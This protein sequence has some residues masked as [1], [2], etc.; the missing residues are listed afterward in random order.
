MC[1]R[2][3]VGLFG[4][5]YKWFKNFYKRLNTKIIIINNQ[6]L[7]LNKSCLKILY[8]TRCV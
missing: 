1:L 6:T 2:R 8:L 4:F 3:K 5:D 7:P